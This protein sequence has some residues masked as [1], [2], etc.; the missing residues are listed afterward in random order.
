MTGR[1]ARASVPARRACS[2]CAPAAVLRLAMKTFRQLITSERRARPLL[3]AHA[4]SSLGTGA[5]YVALLLVAYERFGSAFAVSAIL[6][7]ELLPSV[8][9]GAVL[10]AAADRWSRRTILVVADLVRCA[11]FLGLA[12]VG[13]FEATIALALVVGIG[14]A[15]FQPAVMASLPSLVDKE[16]LPAATGLYGAIQEL[17]YTAGPVLAAAAFLVVDATGILVAN[18][19]TFAAS[20]LL[21]TT[22]RLAPRPAAE[23]DGTPGT[24]MLGAVRDGARALRA[25]RAAWTVVL[26]STAFVT[27]LGAVNVAELVLVRETLG[28]GGTEYALIVASMGLGITVGSLL[29]GSVEG[30]D[31][32][33][34]AYLAG[35]LTCALAMAACALAPSWWVALAAFAALGL[36]NGLALVSENVLLQHVIPDDLKGRVFG[37]KGAF[38][39]SAFLLAY[40]GGGILVAAAGPRPALLATGAGCLAVWVAARAFLR[41]ASRAPLPAP[42]HPVVEPV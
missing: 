33:R 26:S 36:G 37:M 17:G 35:L 14:Q 1:G 18:A 32:S 9:L 38:I 2:S 16:R 39:A 23:E 28:G 6:L 31:R 29:A 15:A 27:F 40:F 7:C 21:L 22:L 3:L 30:P 34:R 13:S 8:A 19:V 41:T 24:S 5:A 12:L 10:G 11:G 20:A 42:A 4:Q 25:N